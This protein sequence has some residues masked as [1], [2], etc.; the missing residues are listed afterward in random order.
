VGNKAD[1]DPSDIQHKIGDLA[2]VSEWVLITQDRVTAFGGVTLDLDPHHIDPASAARGPFG[3]GTAQGCL[4]LSLLPYLMS[5]SGI[6]LVYHHHINYGF[7]RVRFMAPVLVGKRV[8]AKFTFTSA[9]QR[10][11]GGWLIGMRAE[12]EQEGEARPC[13]LADCLVLL[14]AEG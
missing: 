2:G 1:V 12:M 4:T 10:A 9:S 14:D 8:R 5:V 3:V 11:G 7:D 6:G 13:M